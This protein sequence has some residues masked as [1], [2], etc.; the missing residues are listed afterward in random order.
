MTNKLLN[1]K[2]KL[3]IDTSSKISERIQDSGFCIRQGNLEIGINGLLVNGERTSFIDSLQDLEDM[4]QILGSGACGVVKKVRHKPTGKIFAVKTVAIDV[5]EQALDKKLLE[6]KTL[7]QAKHEYIVGFHGAFY[8]EGKLTFVLE[9]VNCGTLADLI[10]GAGPIP[11]NVL[12]K[13]TAQLLTGLEYLH[14]QLHIIHRDIKPQNIL[15]SSNGC[16]KITDFGVSG[17]LANTQAMAQTFIGTAKYM[18]PSRIAGKKHSTKSDIWSLG[19]VVLECAL[20][21]FPYPEENVTYWGMLMAI[22]NQ[23]PPS[24][25]PDRFSSEFCSFISQC[26]QKEE[27][28]TPDCSTL[29]THPWIKKHATSDIN[30]AEW[31]RNTLKR[32]GKDVHSSES[33]TSQY[34]NKEKSS[35]EIPCISSN[36]SKQQVAHTESLTQ[37]DTTYHN[38][39]TS[40]ESIRNKEV[41]ATAKPCILIDTV[42]SSSGRETFNEKKRDKDVKTSK[43]KER[44]HSLGEK[45]HEKRPRRR[46]KEIEEK[47]GVP[48]TILSNDT[49]V[50]VSSTT[51]ATTI[52][53]EAKSSIT[54]NS[55]D[56]FEISFRSVVISDDA[57]SVQKEKKD[58]QSKKQ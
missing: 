6:L 30:V 54:H 24:P 19:L 33:G 50:V 10:Q 56:P 27:E 21:Y 48:N 4:Q 31:I 18:S 35:E 15:I 46:S 43:H 44:K 3:Q 26:L 51:T 41:T 7:H 20:G 53:K 9:Y 14:K 28:N 57:P 2:V 45:D 58:K 8:C 55:D 22:V 37:S 17:E 16:V 34:N 12:A 40:S 1:K 36:V 47:S 38:E 23:P 49:T 42:T 13:L 52:R 32:I 39:L 5:N 25:P 11:E 29:L